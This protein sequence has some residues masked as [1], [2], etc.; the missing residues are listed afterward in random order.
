MR[1][2]PGRH[3]A[4]AV[5]AAV[6]LVSCVLALPV[7]ASAA[8]Y[9]RR[10]AIAPF[11]SLTKEDIG[12]T[13]SVLPRLLASRLKALAG[14]D[15]LLPPFG[16]KSP[17]EAARE[18]KYPLL[19]QGTVAKLGK[20]Y[21]IDVA[22]TDLSTGGSAGAFF[23]AAATEDDIIAQLGLLSG[24]IA[25]KLFGVQGAIRAVSPAPLAAAPAPVPVAPLSIGGIPSAPSP[26]AAPA[27]A[28]PPPPPPPRWPA[29]GARL[30]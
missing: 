15:V 12:E 30:Q 1:I 7:P 25:E 19:L 21:S 8:G 29:G 3:V 20:G 6:L 18:A 10:I 26:Q 14:A 16:G 11:T 22:V 5:L 24:E 27:A 28:P 17:E 4:R 13:V 23:A 9:S 2:F